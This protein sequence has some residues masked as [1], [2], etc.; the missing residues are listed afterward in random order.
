MLLAAYGGISPGNVLQE[1]SG[2]VRGTV[3][4]AAVPTG[5][6]FLSQPA[7]E[8]YSALIPICNR[9]Y[10]PQ[11][12]EIPK[13]FKN[14]FADFFPSGRSRIGVTISRTSAC[15]NCKICEISCPQQAF[16]NGKPDHKCIRCLRCVNLCPK[17]ALR[18][19]VRAVTKNYLL[20]KRVSRWY[21]F[22]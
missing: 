18:F 2:L 22:L 10:Q 9:I 21:V 4:A 16:H 1:V 3:I 19:S 20:K 13:L 7:C 8:D 17:N 11:K 5:H 6:S 14:P 12:A 15:D